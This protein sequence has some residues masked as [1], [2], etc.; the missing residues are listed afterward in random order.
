MNLHGKFFSWMSVFYEGRSIKGHI[1]NQPNHFDYD[2]N[3]PR[4]N[5]LGGRPG[6]DAAT[7]GCPLV[8]HHVSLGSCERRL[9]TL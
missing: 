9:M 4:K 2:E 7:F 6:T 3:P 1:E 5:G 8:C